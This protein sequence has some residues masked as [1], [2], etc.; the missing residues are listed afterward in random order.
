MIVLGAARGEHNT[1]Q[2]AEIMAVGGVG[3]DVNGD[4]SARQLEDDVSG[5]HVVVI[6]CGQDLTDA[7]QHGELDL[8]GEGNALAF[9]GGGVEGGGLGV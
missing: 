9:D 2:V 7:M 8:E 3:G 6:G 1:A 5:T 4:A